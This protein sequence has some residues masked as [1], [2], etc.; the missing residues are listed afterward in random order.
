MGHKEIVTFFQRLSVTLG[1]KF[2]DTLGHN[3]YASSLQKFRSAIFRDIPFNAETGGIVFVDKTL[4][5]ATVFFVYCNRCF[6][7][8]IHYFFVIVRVIKNPEGVF[9]GKTYIHFIIVQMIIAAPTLRLNCEIR[10]LLNFEN[11]ASRTDGVNRLCGN[12]RHRFLRVF[13]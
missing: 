4:F 6:F 1:N 5:L 11:Q 3:I 2:S 8:H 12:K 9:F 13:C 10:G 7:A